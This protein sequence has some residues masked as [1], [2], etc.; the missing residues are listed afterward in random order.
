MPL[1]DC[2]QPKLCLNF[3][4]RI[5]R[6][7]FLNMWKQRANCFEPTFGLYTI[8]LS[9]FIFGG[10]QK[11]LVKHP[12]SSNKPQTLVINDFNNDMEY[13]SMSSMCVCVYYKLLIFRLNIDALHLY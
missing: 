11:G 3:L 4:L 6:F 13:S 10:K 1:D 5:Q 9:F 2:R 12:C 7:L 8:S